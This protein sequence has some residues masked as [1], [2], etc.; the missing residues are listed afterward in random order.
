[1]LDP[2][3]RFDV[4]FCDLMMPHF[5]G[6]DVHSR[7]KEANPELAERFVFITGGAVREDIRAFLNEVPNERLDKPFSSQNLRGIAR[8]FFRK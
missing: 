6:M 8:R 3:E 1:L 7:V 5:T 2:R 4:V